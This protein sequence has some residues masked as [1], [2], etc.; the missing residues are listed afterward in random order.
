MAS[1]TH[2][3]ERG[4]VYPLHNLYKQTLA[5]LA[6]VMILTHDKER[7]RISL[8]TK[9][10]E[11]SPGDMLRNPALVFEKADEMAASFKCCP[12]CT[13]APVVATFA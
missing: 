6:Q 13:L 1:L 5:G 2:I 4:R 8:S 3:K 10:L 12:C 7:G 9:K 11:P